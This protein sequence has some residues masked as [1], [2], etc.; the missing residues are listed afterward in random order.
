V[1]IPALV[2]ADLVGE[3]RP[4]N[5]TGPARAGVRWCKPWH[6][7]LAARATGVSLRT[8]IPWML[9][10]EAKRAVAWDDPLPLLRAFLH[11]SFAHSRARS[12]QAFPPA[13]AEAIHA[14]E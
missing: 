9:S 7:V 11:R 4:R 8:W 12:S 3:P 6:D 2:Y 1:N 13:N 5:A 14:R 10:C